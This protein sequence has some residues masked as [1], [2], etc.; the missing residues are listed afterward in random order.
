MASRV[1][2]DPKRTCPVRALDTSPSA[3]HKDV[4]A[5]A[6]CCVAGCTGP[7]LAHPARN[8]PRL[9]LVSSY[10]NTN[11]RRVPLKP[12]AL[13]P[14]STF[15]LGGKRYLATCQRRACS[16][17]GL[18]KHAKRLASAAKVNPNARAPDSRLTGPL[19][20]SRRARR[21]GR[22]RREQPQAPAA[23]ES[24]RPR[25]ARA[26]AGEP[27]AGRRCDPL[28]PRDAH[29]QR[30][31]APTR[32]ARSALSRAP[33]CHPQREH[34]QF[35]AAF[36]ALGPAWV[37]IAE[38]VPTRD[39]QQVRDHARVAICDKLTSSSPRRKKKPPPPGRLGRRLRRAAA[40]DSAAERVVRML[41]TGILYSVTRGNMRRC[42][43]PSAIPADLPWGIQLF[44]VSG[45]RERAL[46]P[47]AP[48]PVAPPPFSPFPRRGRG[49][50]SS[51]ARCSSRSAVARTSASP[52]A[53]MLPLR[54]CACSGMIWTT[55]S[56]AHRRCV[57]DA[58]TLTHAHAATTTP[59]THPSPSPPP[60]AV[61][62]EVRLR[63]KRVV[64]LRRLARVGLALP[65]AA[66]ERKAGEG[67]G[68]WLAVPDA[69]RGYLARALALP[70]PHPLPRRYHEAWLARE[71][72]GRQ[73]R[74]GP[75]ALPY[76]HVACPY[77]ALPRLRSQAVHKNLVQL[78]ADYGVPMCLPAGSAKGNY[79]RAH[80]GEWD[81]R[82]P[83]RPRAQRARS[84]ACLPRQYGR[85]FGTGRTR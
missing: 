5:T 51:S 59:P 64:Q 20:C 81:A 37:A 10:T 4:V 17:A 34:R 12:G 6:L 58:Q 70:L 82:A 65:R 38:R 44:L 25:G 9:T 52:A 8:R 85:R 45:R 57:G 43:V 55:Q 3:Q 47:H 23:P 24:R 42:A 48:L 40:R 41:D 63:R 76:A 35:S 69:A 54:P 53:S 30:T 56:C 77:A 50:R 21:R 32:A 13:S 11:L 49:S 75:G 7:R 33:P 14:T 2:S 60:F 83:A 18:V 27:A 26:V 28:G 1:R 73:E 29:T 46:A 79:I 80:A 84:S 22:A 19:L 66:G 74:G 39:A 36:G 61:H 31:H 78:E 15:L 16:K 62:A 68:L 71:R 67:R 72:D